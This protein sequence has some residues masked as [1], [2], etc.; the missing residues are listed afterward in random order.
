MGQLLPTHAPA[1]QVL[2]PE[3]QGPGGLPKP[4][5]ARD[6]CALGPPQPPGLRGHAHPPQQ[7]MW[8]VPHLTFSLKQDIPWADHTLRFY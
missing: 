1:H 2:C 6:S 8:P 7:D 4:W 5:P 3:D